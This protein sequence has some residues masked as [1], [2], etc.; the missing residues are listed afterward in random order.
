MESPRELEQRGHV[1]AERCQDNCT[2][3]LN[4]SM[5]RK[6]A[7]C[8]DH[9]ATSESEQRY[10][11][12]RLLEKL[13]VLETKQFETS[14]AHS[15]TDNTHNTPAGE[16]DL[17]QQVVTGLVG[18][19]QAYLG[20]GATSPVQ[21]NE[22]LL[23]ELKAAKFTREAALL[24]YREEHLELQEAQNELAAVRAESACLAET[25][26]KCFCLSQEL[27]RANKQLATSQTQ[28]QELQASAAETS[29]LAQQYADSEA[30][31]AELEEQ[32]GASR[33]RCDELS[34]QLASV[35]ADREQLRESLSQAQ[36]QLEE[37]S[38]AKQS[39]AEAQ[40]EADLYRKKYVAERDHRRQLHDTLQELRGNI[41]VVCR[42]RP[43]FAKEDGSVVDV[44]EEEPGTMV[45]SD[46]LKAR[47]K[48]FDFDRICGEDCSQSDIFE[49]I[50]PSLQSCIDGHHV[51]ILAY[52]QTGAGKTYTMSGTPEQPGINTR[53]LQA[54]FAA[55]A[56]TQRQPSIEVAMMQFYCEHV[57]DLLAAE[58]SQRLEV[59]NLA[60]G[61]LAR[62]QERVSGLVWTPVDTVGEALGVVASG[63]SKRAT[64]A[65]DMNEQSSRSH[66][67]VTLRITYSDGVRDVVSRLNLLDLAGSE[68][69]GRSGAAGNTLKEAQSINKSLSAL[70]DVIAALR[71]GLPHIPYRN[72]KLTQV[73]Q[74]SLQGGSKVLLMCNVSPEQADVSETLSSLGFAERASKVALGN[75]RGNGK[76]SPLTDRQMQPAL[77]LSSGRRAPSQERVPLQASGLPNAVQKKS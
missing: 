21:V 33:Q 64:S 2:L 70:G 3:M 9:K 51:C 44:Q 57:F 75:A 8:T 23:E 29:L 60:A 59:C 18:M 24:A 5:D 66:E 65:T 38:V 22:D 76:S 11:V 47:K 46:T 61:Q 63:R 4:D 73:L 14:S 19:W 53:A 43:R 67:L 26:K 31:V 49:Y 39:L 16:P 77:R 56:N 35:D 62:W 1:D 32:L 27:K 68:R 54:L 25:Q 10:T 45:V 30:G 12:V 52:G 72:S 37:L 28:I 34:C 36:A 7:T 74:D 50:A 71:S 15:S 41:R 55:L 69:V 6:S 20:A 58:S 40:A 42:V 48:R 17:S 13:S